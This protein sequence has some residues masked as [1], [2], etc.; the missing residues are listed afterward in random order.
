MDGLLT[1]IRFAM[2]SLARS[3]SFTILV[4]LTLGLGIGATTTI[5]SM[6]DG[7]LL[8]GLPF[9]DQDRLIRI[10][11][12]HKGRASD[13]NSAA[14]FLDYREQ[15]KSL[16]AVTFY[17]LR[18][19]HLGS[20]KEPRFVLGAVTSHEFF[21]V[22]GVAP[23]LGR[24]LT[25]SDE[26]PD[27]DIVVIS[28]AFW[29]SYFGGRSDVLSRSVI[30]DEQPF[31]VVGVMPPGFEFP[32]Q[33]V[34]VWRPLWLDVSSP[35]FRTDHNLLVVAR[36]TNGV[37]MAEAKQE[38][39]AYGN[40]VGEDYPEIYKTF[41]FGVTAVG[42]RAATVEDV[43]APLLVLLAA[44]VFVLLIAC[45]NVA[46]VLLVR[47]EMREH[48]LAVR[49]ALGASRP[50]IVRQMLVESLLFGVAGGLIGL[51]LAKLALGIVLAFVGNALPR[52]DGVQLDFR[53]LT[54]TIVVSAL[55]G[56]LAGVLPALK[57]SALPPSPMLCAGGRSVASGDRGLR[58]GVLV[59]T[60][61]ALAV[62]LAIGAGLMIRTL[63]ELRRTAV[64]FRTDD[65]VTARI[66]LPRES[67]R[68]PAQIEFFF[69][70]LVARV[71]KVPEVDAAGI[72]WRLPMAA[73]YDNL[74]IVIDGRET[75]TIGEA[76][77]ALFQIA[78]PEYFA[79]LGLVPVRGRLFRHTDTI[80][81]PVVAVVNETFERQL[82][83]GESA[84]GKHVS[85]WSDGQRWAEIVGVVNDIRNLGITSD[86]R[87][88]LYFAYAQLLSNEFPPDHYY[89][90]NARSMA[91]VAHCQGE[92]AAF[93]SS[94]REIVR[95]L[96]P[97][98][99]V[100]QVRTMS[101]ILSVTVRDRELSAGLL[102]VFAC[103]ALVLA[104]VGV[105][106][107]V[108]FTANRRIA[109]MGI[110]MAVGADP[111]DIRRLIVG[112]GLLPVVVG[113]VIG[114]GCGMVAAQLIRGMLYNVR[115]VDPS[116]LIAVLIVVVGTAVVATWI[117]ALR[118]SHVD[119]ADVLRRK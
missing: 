27:A 36:L 29:Q 28:H 98:V 2:R 109:E 97:A 61:V 81:R 59:I 85:L 38:L 74:S 72:A 5:F 46:N 45:A 24:T 79:T 39:V 94:V 91:L 8:R 107:V 104:T 88:M 106:G 118:V 82:L 54:F 115:L 22:M 21:E 68:E 58:S 30:L 112:R 17:Q 99:S 52:V 3:P 43:Q 96:D 67:Y 60:E 89:L 40:R 105:Y 77:T 87:P 11:T 23:E 66:T 73:G 19:W 20:A 44:V 119:P 16:E 65:V 31:A 50:R 92:T 84:V 83:N 10:R 80:G 86:P 114:I 55:A 110:R 48:E 4:I 63:A 14:N 117:P 12:I 6:V 32:N 41:Q 75:E 93:A 26:R 25:T 108:A 15:I 56:L 69:D 33:E 116:I 90:R 62:T 37:S 95:R 70:S 7:V 1:E 103:I 101:E 102:L 78:S 35:G 71:R 49:S 64:G 18:R 34:E 9:P 100:E 42:L 13:A 113:V 53:M 47:Y 51:L 57:I 76:P 111:S